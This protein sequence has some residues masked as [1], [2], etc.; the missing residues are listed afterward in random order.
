MREA[1]GYIND[2]RISITRPQALREIPAIA[3]F[4]AG[5]YSPP[6]ATAP[7]VQELVDDVNDMLRRGWRKTYNEVRAFKEQLWAENRKAAMHILNDLPGS[8]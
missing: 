7:H 5:T 2:E 6:N 1:Y 4:R 3:A 8:L